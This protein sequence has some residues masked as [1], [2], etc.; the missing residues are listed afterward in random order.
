[1]R[2]TSII[3]LTY[4]NLSLTK[5]CIE[6]IFKYTEK[7]S[8]E[9][10]VVDNA[11]TDDTVAYLKEQKDIKTIFNSE[12]VG[13]PKGCNMGI[14]LASKDNDILLLN[15]DTIVTTNWL[16][17]LK[18]CLESDEKIGA[19]GAISNNNDNLQGC[20]FTYDNFEDMQILAA[21]NNISDPKKWERKVCLIGY[22]M[23]IKRSVLDQLGG[24]DEKY[25]LGYIEDNDLS[26]RIINLGYDLMLC[27]DAFI[28]HYLGTAFRKDQE[29]FNQLILKNRAYFEQKWKFKV[30]AFDKTKCFSTFMTSNAQKI[31][32]YHCEIGASSLHIQYLFPTA[33][34]V[35]IEKDPEK[36]KIACKYVP[37]FS[38][39]EEV[40]DQTFDTI[41]IGDALETEDKPLWF[42]YD[43]RKFLT[44]DGQIIG[45]IKNLSSIDNLKLLINETWYYINFQKQNYFTK[46]DLIQMFESLGFKK[47]AI[48]SYKK[49][50][51]KEEKELLEK[52]NKPDLEADVYYYAFCFK[53]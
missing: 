12:N 33:K 49:E 8:Y 42:L 41:F 37:V 39:L 26:L 31:L 43:L 28:H 11:S 22:C 24:L 14:Q 34:V 45:E 25:S 36:A 4:N 5:D 21:K 27:H 50:L 18:I 19:V 9:I 2:K 51:T 48:Y 32:D 3:I 16:K 47:T 10:I 7:D 13:F 23:L 29:K 15:N 30:F 6:S 17:N 53:K 38:S 35:G 44:E 52:M 1:M 46:K 20:D 40:K